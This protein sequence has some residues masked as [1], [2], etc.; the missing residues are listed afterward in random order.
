[1][2]VI[3]FDISNSQIQEIQALISSTAWNNFRIMLGVLVSYAYL[4]KFS[5]KKK[6]F[7][8]YFKI[9]SESQEVTKIV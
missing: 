6:I 1:M 9:I 2:R 8:S 3:C 5:F 7:A 4:K